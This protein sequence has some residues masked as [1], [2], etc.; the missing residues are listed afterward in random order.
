MTFPY[1]L[2][3]GYVVSYTTD[4]SNRERD[5]IVEGV[6]GDKMTATIKGLSPSTTYY[7]RTEARNSKGNGPKSAATSFTTGPGIVICCF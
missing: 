4:L 5:W 1:V 6:V 3:A 2:L 7:F